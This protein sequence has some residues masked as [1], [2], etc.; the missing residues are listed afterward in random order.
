MVTGEAGVGLVAKAQIH[1]RAQLFV[2]DSQL[3]EVNSNYRC[4][5]GNRPQVVA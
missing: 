5:F 4:L 2:N 3:G 1:L